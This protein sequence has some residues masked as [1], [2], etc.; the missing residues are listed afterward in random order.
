MIFEQAKNYVTRGN[1]CV[2]QISYHV[3]LVTYKR[4][5]VLTDEVSA[6]IIQSM[7][8]VLSQWNGALLEAKADVDHIHLLI[9]IPPKYRLSTC[10]GTLKQVSAK[11]VRKEF[12]YMPQ[13]SKNGRLW[14]SSFYVSTVGEADMET[15]SRYIRLQGT[16]RRAGHP[17][18]G[19][20]I[21]T[22]KPPLTS[23]P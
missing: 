9:S 22:R 17:K 1:H 18:S 19:D 6:F 4:E 23:P 12:Y 5:K 10:I 15:V 21:A 13:L 2:Y 3:V 14:S 8:N 11:L 7:G 16:D 20:C